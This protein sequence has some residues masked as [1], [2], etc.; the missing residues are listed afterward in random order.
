MSRTFEC[1][2]LTAQNDAGTT[3]AVVVPSWGANVIALSYHAKD[4][5]WSIPVL[6]PVDAASIAQRPTS[7]GMPILA[8][9]P[10]RVG[11]SQNGMF[12]YQNRPYRIQPTRHGFVRNMA[13]KVLEH[14]D[15]EL[16]CAVE[17]NMQSSKNDVFPFQFEAVHYISIV[18]A[19]LRSRICL[20]NTGNHRQPLNVGWHPY[21]HRLGDCRVYIPAQS[22]WE[23]DENV[24]PVPTGRLLSVEGRDDFRQGRVISP[25]EHWDDIFADLLHDGRGVRCWVEELMETLNAFGKCVPVKAR[26]SV[27]LGSNV[28]HVQLYTPPGRRAISIEP[29][30]SPPDAINLLARRHSHA[31]VCELD[32]GATADFEITVSIDLLPV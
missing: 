1:Y 30:S 2:S 16:K 9:T 31:H 17:V 12:T 14:S 15:S 26:R 29:L 27:T 5:Q 25:E 23:L 18:D 4:F 3:A 11:T 24:E 32:P 8:P 19:G 10:G 21:L 22:R 6:E 28:R 7:F 20:Q 13:W